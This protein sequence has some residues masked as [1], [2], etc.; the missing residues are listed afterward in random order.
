[1]GRLVVQASPG[2]TRRS[3]PKIIKAKRAGSMAQVVDTRKALSSNSS[4]TT[5]NRHTHTHTGKGRKGLS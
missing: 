3:N 4:T 5:H 1:M 2:K